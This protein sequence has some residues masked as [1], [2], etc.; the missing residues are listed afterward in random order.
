[1]L[2]FVLGLVAGCF[3]PTAYRLT[4]QSTVSAAWAWIKRTATQET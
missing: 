1:M 2:Y 4:I 3:V